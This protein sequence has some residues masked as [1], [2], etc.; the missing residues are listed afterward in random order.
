MKEGKL[1]MKY[2]FIIYIKMKSYNNVSK[3][4]VLVR[5]LVPFISPGVKFLLK[6]MSKFWISLDTLNKNFRK[7][8]LIH[9]DYYV[10][11]S[12]RCIRSDAK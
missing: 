5:C 4:N 8:I 7:N 1:T 3:K 10:R 11:H 6:T 2:D 9:L 12:F